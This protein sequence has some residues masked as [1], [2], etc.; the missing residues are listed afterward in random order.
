MARYDVDE[1]LS[2]VQSQLDKARES[3]EK[4]AKEQEKFSKKLLV[5]DTI[6]KGATSYLNYRAD[7]LDQA[8]APARSKYQSYIKNAN[9]TLTYW[10]TVTKNGGKDY[11]QK[12]IFNSYLE[13]AKTERPF[14]EVQMNFM[15]H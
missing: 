11:L 15:Q 1:Q 13:A 3:R 6:L 2:F 8:N 12:Q 4:S 10:D 14:E 5:T 9:D 7:K